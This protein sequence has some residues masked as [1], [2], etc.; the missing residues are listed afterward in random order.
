MGDRKRWVT[1]KTVTENLGL[2]DV[3]LERFRPRIL[4]L[5]KDISPAQSIVGKGG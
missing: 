5:K 1:E 2:G 3:M 4:L